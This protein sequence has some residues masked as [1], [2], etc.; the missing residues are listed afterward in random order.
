MFCALSGEVIANAVVSTETGHIYEKRLIEKYLKENDNKCPI[1]GNELTSSMLVTVCT[2]ETA[3]PRPLETSSI[4]SILHLMQSEW[5]TLMLESFN[6]KKDLDSTRKELSN[7]LYQLDAACRVIARLSSKD[8][9]GQEMEV[10]EKET[11]NGSNKKRKVMES[12]GLPE[13]IAEKLKTLN[14]DLTSTRKSTVKALKEEACSVD[15]IKEMSEVDS[16]TPHKSDKP[17]ICCLQVH[18]SKKI[19]TGGMDGVVKLFN[20]KTKKVSATMSRHSKQVTAIEVDPDANMDLIFSAS[21]DKTVQVWKKHSERSYKPSHTFKLYEE[22]VSDLALHVSR[23]YLASCSLDGSW[24]FSDLSTGK[25]VSKQKGG[26]QDVLTCV[27][28]HPDACLVATGMENNGIRMWD[29]NSMENVATFEAGQGSVNDIAFSVNGYHMVSGDSEGYLRLWD[30][31]KL[32]NILSLESASGPI[33]SVNYGPNGVYLAVGTGNTVAMYHE[34][35][36]KNWQMFHTL[37]KHTAKVTDVRISSDFSY[38][39]STSMDRSLKLY[40]A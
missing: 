4:P 21:M 15:E 37:D 14:Q 13:E 31:R 16:F 27:D 23:E 9:S 11:S 10:E 35:S 24:D 6:L 25:S 26:D 5:D 40:T 2:T 8:K 33:S 18:G 36:K 3:K 12:N 32:S 38:I 19:V 28:F 17:G 30:L 39:A 7:A 1:S 20:A 29:L 34:V 22:G